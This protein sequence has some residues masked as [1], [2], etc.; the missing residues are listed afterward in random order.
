MDLALALGFNSVAALERGMSEAE[1]NQWYAYRAKKML[2]H[3]RQEYYLAQIALQV[4]ASGGG[5]NLKL[6]D[7]MFDKQAK[8]SD[9]DTTETGAAKIG[10]L[11]GGVKVVRLGQRRKRG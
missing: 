5:K 2:P 7:F 9:V 3:R 8:E 6:S 10:A 1:L 11:V 4:F